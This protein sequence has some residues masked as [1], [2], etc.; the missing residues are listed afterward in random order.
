M[1][2]FSTVLSIPFPYRSFCIKQW[3]VFHVSFYDST[4]FDTLCS[5]IRSRNYLHDKMPVVAFKPGQITNALS[6]QCMTKLLEDK[7]CMPINLQKQ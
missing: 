6:T 7:L 4:C 3:S 1:N 2:S 5:Q